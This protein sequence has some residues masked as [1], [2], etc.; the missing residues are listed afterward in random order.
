MEATGTVTQGA[1]PRAITFGDVARD[2]I[3]AHRAS[4]R[5]TKLAPQW[6]STLRAHSEP[7]LG[8][9]FAAL[10]FVS[11]GASDANDAWTQLTPCHMRPARSH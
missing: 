4:W 5:N 10:L 7:A 6:D 1:A 8:A 11:S 9:K 3:R 2:H